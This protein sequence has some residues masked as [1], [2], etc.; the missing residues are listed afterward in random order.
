MIRKSNGS[1][2]VQYH[3]GNLPVYTKKE[4]LSVYPNYTAVSHWHD[5]VEFNAVLSGH[6]SFNVNG[7]N[8]RIGE[9][10]GIFIN[11]RQLHY[12]FSDDH[13]ECL[14]V[15]LIFHPVLLCVTEETEQNLIRPV[16]ENSS[17]PFLYLKP[18]NS[19]SHL[20]MEG[21]HRLCD[22]C[23]KETAPLLALGELSRIW[24]ALYFLTGN[25]KETN[26]P[27]S[28]HL[29]IL[30]DMIAY[31]QSHYDEKITTD[32]LSHAGN[33]GKTACWSIFQEYTSQTPISYLTNYRLQKAVELLRS[34]D[35]SITQIA[36]ETG[37]TG[38]SYFTE[39]F[40]KVY[41][42]TPTEYR[43]DSRRTDHAYAVRDSSLR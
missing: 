41:H 38:A 33:V 5:D 6:M 18:E 37:F 10:E 25:Q 14:F 19:E 7:R 32:T 22:G 40:R 20:I 34:T 42:C 28:H 11:S 36:C 4:F 24:E 12:G 26:I 30:K 31:I 3:V 9:G 23:K 27:G 2:N 15:C 43:R 17:C 35:M 39:T 1:E 21:M 29:M 16:L 13:T 8:V